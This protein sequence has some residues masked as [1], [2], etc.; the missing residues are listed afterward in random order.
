MSRIRRAN[1]TNTDERV[2]L[3]SEV[4]QGCLAMKMMG[5]EQPLS[6]Q[7][8]EIRQSEA[9][10]VLSMAR[11]RAAIMAIQFSVVSLVTFITFSVYR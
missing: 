6:Q 2:R 11:I 5:W 3:T 9:K 1:A 8:R 4:I 7:I 10:H